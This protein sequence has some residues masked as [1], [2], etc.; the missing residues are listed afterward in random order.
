MNIVPMN[1]PILDNR[2]P[3][4]RWEFPPIAKDMTEPKKK[5]KKIG[6]DHIIKKIRQRY[7]PGS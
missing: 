6:N 1:S 4:K 5:Q 3:V 2:T 7:I